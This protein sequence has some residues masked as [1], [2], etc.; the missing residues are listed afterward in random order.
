MKIVPLMEGV[1]F[2]FFSKLINENDE[3]IPNETSHK[4]AEIMLTEL[5]R[6]TKGLKLIKE[7][8]FN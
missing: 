6:W 5:I 1:N 2:S 7:N 3:F 4:A 8:K